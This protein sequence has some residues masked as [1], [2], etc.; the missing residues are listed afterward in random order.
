MDPLLCRGKVV[1]SAQEK[2]S[3]VYNE[4]DLAT[5]DEVRRNIPISK[6]KQLQAYTPATPNS[7]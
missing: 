5:V 4:V 3:I 6:Q 1:A 2:E 7:S